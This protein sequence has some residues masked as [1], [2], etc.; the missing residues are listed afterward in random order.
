MGVHTGMDENIRA[1]FTVDEVEYTY[2]LLCFE[3]NPKREGYAVFLGTTGPNEY[4]IYAANLNIPMQLCLKSEDYIDIGSSGMN[5][6]DL[7][8]L[9]QYRND[10]ERSLRERGVSF[11]LVSSYVEF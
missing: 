10:I 7:K 6:S 11:R 4:L 9:K 8:Q 2:G 5:G 1:I 3:L